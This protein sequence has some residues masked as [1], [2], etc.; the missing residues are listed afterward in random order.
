MAIA[1]VNC[2]GGP[3]KYVRIC[4]VRTGS[5]PTIW[6]STPP[7]KDQL[8][9]CTF[10]KLSQRHV[11][12]ISMMQPRSWSPNCDLGILVPS[13]RLDTLMFEYSVCYGIPWWIQKSSNRTP[14]ELLLEEGG[15]WVGLCR[16]SELHFSTSHC[17][18]LLEHWSSGEAA[19]LGRP[20]LT[21]AF[22]TTMWCGLRQKG[23][24]QFCTVWCGVQLKIW[25]FMNIYDIY[26]HQSVLFACT[27]V[28]LDMSNSIWVTQ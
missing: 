14:L 24:L 12:A 15:W 22:E 11:G 1:V 18:W 13:A 5:Y 8:Q 21:K 3:S 10:L 4:Q 20:L 23:E 2:L 28:K 27:N 25:H 9:L 6:T 17:H 19:L 16:S 26:G 7:G